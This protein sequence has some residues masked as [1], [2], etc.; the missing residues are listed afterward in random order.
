M[1]FGMAGPDS[2]PHNPLVS[3]SSRTSPSVYP[4][5]P[6]PEVRQPRCVRCNL[7]RPVDSGRQ[8]RRRPFGAQT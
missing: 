5:R 3:A 7:D 4:R 6:P 8:R 2:F 1:I